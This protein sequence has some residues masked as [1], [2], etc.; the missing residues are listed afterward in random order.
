MTTLSGDAPDAWINV[1][2]FLCNI[3][4]GKKVNMN[5]PLCRIGDFPKE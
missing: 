3:L 4:A 1:F 2:S 5:L